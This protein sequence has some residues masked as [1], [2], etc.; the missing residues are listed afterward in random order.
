MSHGD[1]G[2]AQEKLPCDS[3]AV[4]GF[5][6]WKVVRLQSLAKH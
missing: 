1:V 4:V 5:S 2:G 6:S 3:P